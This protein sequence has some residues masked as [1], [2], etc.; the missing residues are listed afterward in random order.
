MKRFFLPILV[1]CA[2]LLPFAFGL[3]PALVAQPP[4]IPVYPFFSTRIISIIDQLN[5]RG[6]TVIRIEIGLLHA[7]SVTNVPRRFVPGWNYHIYA[8]SN[9][10]E[11]G[12]IDLRLYAQEMQGGVPQWVLDMQDRNNSP[13]AHLYFEV[14]ATEDR[15]IR[16]AG[17]RYPNEVKYGK[18]C[19]IV[20][21]IRKN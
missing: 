6:E 17:Y 1:R 3:Q 5:A 20:S 10:D 21:G 18:Y 7:D 12:D 2:F 16:I 8:F 13:D 14:G 11:I 4:G 15:Q 9:P 19:V